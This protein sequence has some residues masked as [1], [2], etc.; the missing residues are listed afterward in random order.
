MGRGTSINDVRNKHK[1]LIPGHQV[2]LKKPEGKTFE[3]FSDKEFDAFCTVR[4]SMIK[5]DIDLTYMKGV[6]HYIYSLRENNKQ[7]E[8]LQQNIQ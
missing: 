6:Q 8:K 7:N 1:Y 3:L 4:K 5:F 2:E